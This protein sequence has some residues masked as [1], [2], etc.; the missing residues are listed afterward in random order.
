MQRTTLCA[1]LWLT[2]GLCLAGCASPNSRV[3]VPAFDAEAGRGGWPPSQVRIR[4]APRTRGYR[5]FRPHKVPH[6]SSTTQAAFA[7]QQTK[8]TVVP[9]QTN[10]IEA[11]AEPRPNS[12]EW[13]LREN[14]RVG[15]AIIICRVCLT[16]AAPASGLSTKELPTE[17]S[18]SDRNVR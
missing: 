4:E 12:K 8:E 3:L 18:A 14:T 10:G 5:V 9:D 7:S 2:L 6:K 11:P 17:M 1:S 16:R 15:K 13:W